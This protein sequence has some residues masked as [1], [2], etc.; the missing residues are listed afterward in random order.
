MTITE[1]QRQVRMG[2]YETVIHAC[3]PWAELAPFG[4]QISNQTLQYAGL[5]GGPNSWGDFKRKYEQFYLFHLRE[6]D[7]ESTNHDIQWY[8]DQRAIYEAE[9][10][11]MLFP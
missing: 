3:C 9:V 10:H 8:Q 5:A 11:A 2:M 1:M 6:Q 4:T 7:A